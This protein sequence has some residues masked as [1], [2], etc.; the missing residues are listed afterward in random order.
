MKKRIAL[1]LALVMILSL[2]ACGGSGSKGGSEGGSENSP[3]GTGVTADTAVGDKITMGKLDGEALTW[4]AAG[5]GVGTVLL[6][7]DKVLMRRE[8]TGEDNNSAT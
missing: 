4:T 6:I 8:F 5:K 7:S 1:L 3:A 2:A